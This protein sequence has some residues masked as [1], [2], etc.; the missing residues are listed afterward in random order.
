MR[1][2]L[3]LAIAGGLVV[4]GLLLGLSPST[5]QGATQPFSC[6]SP[7]SLD[8]K[9]IDR[10][11]YIDDLANGTVGREVWAT[12]YRQ[13]CEDAFAGRGVW[14]W[15]V[16]GAGV[17]LAGGVAVARRPQSSGGAPAQPAEPADNG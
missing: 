8:T 3:L 11:Q 5:V 6:G 10:Q 14:A 1:T 12:D 4:F 16:L 2:G 13:R 17:L 9:E 7:W 15:L